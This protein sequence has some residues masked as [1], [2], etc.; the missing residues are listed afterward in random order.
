MRKEQD[1]K[2]EQSIDLLVHFSDNESLELAKLFEEYLATET[3]AKSLQ[4]V[5]PKSKPKWKDYA[6]VKE[7]EVDDLKLKVGMTAG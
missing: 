2:V 3:R 7:W 6:V 5:G 4:L 1:L